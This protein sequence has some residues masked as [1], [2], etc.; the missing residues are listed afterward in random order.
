MDI[1]KIK[2]NII[3]DHFPD[4]YNYI[5]RYFIDCKLKYFQ[6]GNYDYSKFPPDILSV[7]K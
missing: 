2:I 3:L 5:A 4:Y 7:H 6:D 1:L